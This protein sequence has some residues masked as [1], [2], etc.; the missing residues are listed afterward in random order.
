MKMRLIS[1]LAVFCLLAAMV[2]AL[3][4]AADGTLPGVSAK[5]P[6]IPTSGD[7][8]DGSV[9]EP[10]K[11]VQKDWNTYY[12]ITKCAE[13][14]YVAKEGG[15]WLTRNYILENDLILNAGT[16]NYSKDGK[17][18]TSPS[19]RWTP[20]A[21]EDSDFFSG[22]FD[23]NGHTISGLY[24][25][26]DSY[27]AGL[28][29][30]A[31]AA[32]I[33][34]LTVVNGYVKGIQDVGGIVGR[35]A[36]CADCVFSGAVVGA[37]PYSGGTLEIS[38]QVGG[39]VGSGYLCTGC[40]FYG[41][42]VSK[43]AGTGGIMGNTLYAS[44]TG[45]EDCVSYGTVSGEKY[46]GGVAGLGRAKRCV[47]Y[48][49]V[50]GTWY[51]GGVVGEGSEGLEHCAN[52]GAV[53]GTDDVGGVVG[54]GSAVNC[55]NTA[56]VKGKD[57]VGGI[58]GN[59]SKA[60][61]NCYTTGGVT[62]TGKN[63][64][65]VA[66]FDEKS[67]STANAKFSGCYYLKT[68]T[69]NAGLYGLGGFGDSETVSSD[70]EGFYP[71]RADD[72][73]QQAT[74]D[75]WDFSTV[76][77]ISPSWNDGYPHLAMEIDLV[78]APGTTYSITIDP[79][80]EHG[81]V[82]ADKTSA[83]KG[84][85][86]TLTITPDKGYQLK[87]LTVTPELTLDGSGSA[88]TFTMPENDVEISATFEPAPLTGTV[89]VT[90]TARSGETL[91]ASVT[92]SNNTGTLSYQWNADGEPIT[93]AKG[94]SYTLTD[95]EVGK[96][97]TCEVKSDV[98]TGS[99]TSKE[100]GPVAKVYAIT[101]DPDIEDGSV[102]ADKTVATA[103]ETVTLT[104]TPDK[105]YQ[106]KELTVTPDT[107][108][109]TDNTFTMP[110]SDVE[111]SAVFEPAPLT[112]DV[113]IT[114]T[115]RSGQTLTASVTGSNNTGTLSYQWN[116]DGE[117]IT[118]AKGKTYTLTDAEVGKKITCEVK[119][120]VQT[121]SI[122]SEETG[123]VTKVY[124]ITID[125]DIEDGSVSADKDS[126]EAGETVTLTVTPDKGYQLKEL[127][128]TPD[129]VVIT[130]NTFTMP[131]N[132]V[133]ISAVFE[134][135]PLTGDVAIT[136][137][138]RS[139]QTLTASVT[140][141]NN[142]GT[143]SYQWN[144]DGEP[145]TDAKGKTYTLTDAEVGK[146]ITCEVK[147]DVQTG[148]ITSE[149]T[150]TVTSASSPDPVSYTVTFDM[151]GHGTAPEAQAIPSGGKVTKPADP[152]ADGYTF[153][154]WFK[155]AEKTTA[156]DF[157]SE[158]ITKDTVIYAKWT[159]NQSSG[160]DKPSAVTY[161]ITV[162]NMSN[163]T[164]IVSP[165]TAKKGDTVTL[166][167]T[168]TNG[169]HLDTIT[170]MPSLT[171]DGSGSTR[172][173]TMPDSNVTVSATFA[174]NSSASALTGYVDIEGEP[175][176]GE[177]LRAVVWSTNNTGTLYYQWT[178]DGYN[179]YGET[180]RYLDLTRYEVGAVIRCVVTSSVQTGSITGRLW[181]TVD[182]YDS[183]YYPSSGSTGNNTSGNN[184][185][186]NGTNQ[187]GNSSSTGAGNNSTPELPIFTTAANADGTKTTTINQP[188]G[189]S[190]LVATTSYGTVSA[191]SMT[192]SSSAVASAL[193][194]GSALTIP[195]AV[196]PSRDVN[197]ATPVQVVLPQA[198][199]A[200]K[201][202]IPVSRMTAG[203][204]AVIQNSFGPDRVIKSSVSGSDGVEF[205]LTGSAVVKIVD[206]TKSFLD[207]FDDAWYGNAVK[208]ASSRE[209]MNGVSPQMFDPQGT[210]NRAMMTQ[211]LYNYD[212]AANTGVV[213]QF[214]DVS[215]RDWY[216]DSVS[217]ATKNG[218]AR[219]AG[220]RFGAEDALTREDMVAMLYN[221]AKAK[222]YST[223]ASG[224][225]MAFP[226]N[227]DVSDWARSAMQ[228]AVGAGLINGT[229]N[230]TRT[231]I[232]D[233]QGTV[234]RAQLATIMQRFNNLY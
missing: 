15:V 12:V 100:M 17:L 184:S 73:K 109:I 60:S 182:Y 196:Q 140:G 27:N 88:R 94:E 18:L 48:G 185:T 102:T 106:L 227:G 161:T 142:T 165:T 152:T 46:V 220:G 116:A 89:A 57:N 126:A 6:A 144:A 4:R 68:T 141:S 96:K 8:W 216:A 156:F 166:T 70:T 171:L 151:G 82:T 177:R 192:F 181:G 97:I 213:S 108:V 218:I 201:V 3:A 132:D 80:I 19:H 118:D 105:G 86:V 187:S 186:S 71:K 146:K 110:E 78:G 188:D 26:E 74:F 217:W 170:T 24:V 120:D 147:S 163:G 92:G 223:S 99:I 168:P 179:L 127:T 23:G 158:T 52:Y 61:S 174:A 112:G 222:G 2:P 226:D 91:T 58:V 225:T 175:W 39:I 111:I 51:V 98:Q 95:A 190:G 198:T 7:R 131:E 167:I 75:G 69:V 139:G 59:V 107:V 209:V 214:S 11:T 20:I 219:N 230:G 125:P 221:Y 169:Y 234:T 40:V 16:L 84:D 121:G 194:T 90:G 211:M 233:P 157:D 77:C 83:R 232:L 62:G 33:K 208:W 215:S 117:P 103:G 210:M 10:S 178:A 150:D 231:V 42:V 135:A 35:G 155:D 29:G 64:G 53:S 41:T 229:Q 72:L 143:L 202:K 14:A 36:Y 228:W 13:L 128:A 195:A 22:I 114:G 25:D 191:A 212:D 32:T 45:A 148:S 176:V 79:D 28:F 101:I 44:I 136:G 193:R 123:P 129:T 56:A 133:K 205:E 55:Y 130:D 38:A 93:D 200:V 119:S 31:G 149:E 224:N 206:N 199:G 160:D 81:G 153:G 183:R 137:T 122:T 134:P 9:L 197:S 87:E 154:G 37:L 145:I 76:W 159:E 30:N 173:F 47:N 43:G 172:T 204:V 104:V 49:T 115:A 124:G 21:K 1:L 66:G 203:T 138:A 5:T 113:A 85:T 189:S 180:S 50:S 34:N 164:V 162:A 65:A 63:I 67:L 207:V 54:D